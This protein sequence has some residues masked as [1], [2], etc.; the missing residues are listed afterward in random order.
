VCTTRRH[1]NPT[2]VQHVYVSLATLTL[3]FMRASTAQGPLTAI[4][5][6][7]QLT[8]SLN[9]TAN[10]PTRF[11]VQVQSPRG[12]PVIVFPSV[13]FQLSYGAIYISTLVRC[14]SYGKHVDSPTPGRLYGSFGD[15]YLKCDSIEF[16]V[17]SSEI[18]RILL[19]C[20]NKKKF[21]RNDMYFC[22]YYGLIIN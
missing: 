2:D 15:R 4:P 17:W 14:S 20:T 1:R 7:P 19:L 3:Q 6:R 13:S 22:F 8:G 11:N 12:G 21:D 5:D 9:T 18:R 16:Q 10:L